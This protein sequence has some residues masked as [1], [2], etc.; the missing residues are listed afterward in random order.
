KA[1]LID[2]AVEV[3]GPIGL[4]MQRLLGDS[5]Y[6]DSV[7]S[8]GGVRAHAI[9]QPILDDLYDLVGLAR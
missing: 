5:D 8:D 4:E 1:R 9:S 3:L 2:K 6:I 7:L